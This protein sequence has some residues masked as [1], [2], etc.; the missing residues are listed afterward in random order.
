MPFNAIAHTR[1]LGP[2]TGL[3]ASKSNIES[4][5]P[6]AEC[7]WPTGNCFTCYIFIW[8]CSEDMP[9]SQLQLL[10]DDS[11]IFIE[12]A[13]VLLF[14]MVLQISATRKALQVCLPYRGNA[15]IVLL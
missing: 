14:F 2:A 9:G 3:M 10:Q 12:H 8:W 1:R 7:Q 15:V 6:T 11:A 5:A 4:S 13:L